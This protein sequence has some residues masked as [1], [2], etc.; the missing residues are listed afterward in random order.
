MDLP[1]VI[2]QSLALGRPVIV[3]DQ[4]PISEALLGDGGYTVPYG[5]V[6]ALTRSLVRLLS[7]VGL[8]ERLGERG[9]D[10][11]LEHCDPEKVVER[12][13]V[14]YEQVAGSVGHRVRGKTRCGA[15]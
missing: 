14:V 9:R 4:A 6:P 7:D 1:L 15:F 2:L 3:G 11:V 8:R 10:S 12:Y 13:Q 5:D